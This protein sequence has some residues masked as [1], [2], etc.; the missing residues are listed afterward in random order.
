[1]SSFTSRTMSLDDDESEEGSPRPKPPP[2]PPGEED[3][4]E[5]FAKYAEAYYTTLNVGSSSFLGV[6][7][8]ALD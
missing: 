7:S 5:E 2:A 1:M 4:G 3:K 6:G 8:W